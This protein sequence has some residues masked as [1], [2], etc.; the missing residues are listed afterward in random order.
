VTN[1]VEILEEAQEQ[2]P[3][4]IRRAISQT[5]IEERWRE[6][7]QNDEESLCTAI[8]PYVEPKTRHGN[9][10]PPGMDHTTVRNSRSSRGDL[11]QSERSAG[12]T[13]KRHQ[14][15]GPRR[16]GR[17]PKGGRVRK[18]EMFICPITKLPR[19]S[20]PDPQNEPTFSHEDEVSL[21]LG[22]TVCSKP[23]HIVCDAG[24]ACNSLISMGGA[25]ATPTAA[26][27]GGGIRLGA[28]TPLPPLMGVPPPRRSAEGFA[29]MAARL[30]VKD[31]DTLES[32]LESIDP[33]Q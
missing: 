29:K 25:D 31:D 4:K 3:R 28:G 2:R 14:Q 13:H 12:K 18:D 6:A 11:D 17:I 22:E 24:T 9:L 19:V 26:D 33:F 7:R 15:Q 16:K 8:V 23:S 5:E 30:S 20:T 27:K 10:E 1:R 32:T 21:P